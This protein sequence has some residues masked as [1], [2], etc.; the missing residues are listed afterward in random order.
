MTL[1]QKEEL[2]ACGCLLSSCD[3][4]RCKPCPL[5]VK[6][7]RYTYEDFMRDVK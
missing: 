5:N 4:K 1:P 2:G 6:N 7:Q 3:D